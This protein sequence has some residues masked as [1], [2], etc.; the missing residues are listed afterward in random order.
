M[1]T[2][3]HCTFIK[4]VGS[5]TH[6]CHLNLTIYSLWIYTHTRV[7]LQVRIEGG[8]IIGNHKKGATTID[9]AISGKKKDFLHTRTQQA[10]EKNHT[11]T[12]QAKGKKKK[13][14]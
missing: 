9:D 4:A 5:R 13:Q 10:K 6:A 8:R 14:R 1:H 2:T 3:A 11:R 12:Q 7:S